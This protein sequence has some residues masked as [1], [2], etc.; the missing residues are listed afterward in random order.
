MGANIYTKLLSLHSLAG[1]D[2]TF[3]SNG[4][5]K[6]TV[7]TKLLSNKHLQESALFFTVAVPNLT[8]LYNSRYYFKHYSKDSAP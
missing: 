8:G 1:C 5:G 7:F 4:V 2:T 3:S 6:A